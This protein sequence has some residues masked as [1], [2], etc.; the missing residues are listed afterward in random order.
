MNMK[1]LITSP[2]GKLAEAKVWAN[3]GKAALLWVLLHHSE[4]VIKDWSVLL[5][6]VCGLIAPDLLKK[7]I[8]LRT[9]GKDAG[10]N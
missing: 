6:F 10:T 7:L 8:T 2:D 5:V 3:L 4:A 9:G 1:D